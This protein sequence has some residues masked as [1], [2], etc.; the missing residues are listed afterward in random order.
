MVSSEKDDISRGHDVILHSILGKTMQD[1]KHL[2]VFPRPTWAM[3]VPRRVVF[4]LL[5]SRG[6]LKVVRG[7]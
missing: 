3:I 1:V 6:E 2:P 4:Q 7:E 5:F